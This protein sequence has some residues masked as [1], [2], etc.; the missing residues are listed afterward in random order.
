[1]KFISYPTAEDRR[2]RENGRVLAGEVLSAAP[3]SGHW[4]YVT[5]ER[6]CYRVF[7]PAQHRAGGDY[8]RSALD[9]EAK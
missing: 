4:V 9:G 7:G 6:R 1:M 5:E 2:K 8:V 3:P